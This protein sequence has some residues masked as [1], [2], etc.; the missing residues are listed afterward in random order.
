[1]HAIGKEGGGG[2]QGWQGERGR[3]IGREGCERGRERDRD[4]RVKEEREGKIF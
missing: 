3:E 4:E 1:V 2:R